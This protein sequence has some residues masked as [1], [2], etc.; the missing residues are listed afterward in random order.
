M[1]KPSDIQK[2]GKEQDCRI[3]PGKLKFYLLTVHA[4]GKLSFL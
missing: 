1:K 2:Q 3:K 4:I